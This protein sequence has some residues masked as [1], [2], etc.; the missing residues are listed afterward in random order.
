MVEERMVASIK[1]VGDV[2]YTAWINAGQPNLKKLNDD[3]WE[4]T[5]IISDPNIKTRAHTN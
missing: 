1:A 5:P 3:V 2:W 4:E